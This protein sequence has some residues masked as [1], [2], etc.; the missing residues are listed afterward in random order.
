MKIARVALD[1]PLD[2]TFDFRIAET[3]A[4]IG[5]VVIVP[6]GTRK[7]VGVV[8]G[9]SGRSEV[10]A[11]RLK[12]I[13]RVVG[14]VPPFSENDLA[15]ARFCARYYQ[16]G[17]G[18]VLAA[19]LPPRLRQVRR[20]AIAP[21]GPSPSAGDGGFT[22]IHPLTADQERV[23]ED[24]RAGFGRFH[25][26]LLQGVTGSGKTEVYLHLIAEALR[27]GTQ[28]LL[29]VPEIALTPQLEQHV[30]SRF[31]AANLVA[32]HSHLAEG[33]RAR[34]WLAAQ[35]GAAQVV[36]GTRLAILMPFARLGLIVVD[37]EHDPSYKQQEGLRYSARDV[38][39][40]RAQQLAI[41]AVLGS[42]TP[43]LESYDNALRGRYSHQVLPARAVAGAAM[44]AVRTID[45][46]ADRPAEGLTHALVKALRER[47]ERGEQSLVFIN[48]RGFAPVLHC[49]ACGWHS[50]CTRCTA[51]LVLHL[52]AGEL[53]CHHC[54]HRE[55]AS[56]RCPNC[57]G[58]DIAPIGHGTQRIEEALAEAV[59]GAA[60]ARVDR[61]AASARGALKETFRKVR[62]GEVDILVGTQMLAKGHDY[63]NLTLVGVLEA[64]GALFSADFRSSERLFALVTQV[65]GRAGRGAR[66]GEV[67]IQTDFPSHPLYAAVARH[68]YARFAA[69]ALEERRLAEFPPFAHLALLRA[70]SKNAGEAAAFLRNA[71]RVG[72]RLS[73]RV[74]VFDPVSPPLE[75]K[76]GFERSQLLVRARSRGALQP[77]LAEWRAAL[78]TRDDRR[79]RWSL[80]V[81]PQEV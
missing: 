41:P 71:A 33:D 6:F 26:V 44:P 9:R 32:A 62:E 76:A 69:D 56:P 27:R 55:R 65:A 58:E 50:T 66:P 31:P 38:A 52:R 25:P 8:V 21:A 73:E 78:A 49:R 80:D 12:E 36:L 30:R 51:N 2:E 61:D 13:E 22:S 40:R 37:E 79:V 1:L 81:D 60:I 19:S 4:A 23:L 43:S 15:L 18:E 77:F 39:V 5:A 7:K 48:R 53:R 11:A 68:D 75:R 17:L 35:A 59:P 42:A 63:P 16:R 54:G 29:L 24:V 34:A 20:R 57:G 10:P 3:N 46:R 67:L 72:R 64:D 74:E 14:D 45:S 28:A 47:R 70:E